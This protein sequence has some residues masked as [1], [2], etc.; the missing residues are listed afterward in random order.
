M[1]KIKCPKCGST[2][3]MPDSVYGHNIKEGE[4]NDTPNTIIRQP[5]Q[6]REENCGYKWEDN[7]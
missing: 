5:N 1:K 4:K 2:Y 6:C 7:K 3:V